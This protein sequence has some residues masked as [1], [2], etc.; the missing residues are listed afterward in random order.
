MDHATVVALW[1]GAGI[2]AMIWALLWV[3]RVRIMRKKLRN[4]SPRSEYA[5]KVVRGKLP[6][7][8]TMTPDGNIIGVPTQTGHFEVE[9]EKKLKTDD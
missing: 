2:S 4:V 1:F 3:V 5:Y 7:G 9:L 6:P 8:L